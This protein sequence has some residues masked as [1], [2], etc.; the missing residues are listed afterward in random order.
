MDVWDLAATAGRAVA[1]YA[2]MLLVVR[3]L[4]KRTVGNFS[5]FDLIVALMLGEVVDEM[6]YGDV[7]MVKGAVAIGAIAAIKY[8]TAWLSYASPAAARI[9]EGTPTA[10]IVHGELQRDGMRSELMNEADV[11]SALR[12][13]SVDDRRKVAL[14]QVETDGEVSVIE[15]P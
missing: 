8:A 5:A 10:V 3:L 9:L 15:E 2:L 11:D 1:V 4:G 13:R 12:L 7:P 14:A 6:I